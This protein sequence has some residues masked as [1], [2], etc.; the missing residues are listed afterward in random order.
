MRRRRGCGA[1]VG[2]G[3]QSAVV[4]GRESYDS[5]GPFRHHS[6]IDRTTGD[7]VLLQHQ[8]NGLRGVKRRIAL[9]AAPCAGGQRSFELIGKPE[10]VHH[11]AAGLVAKHTVHARSLH[12]DF[13][14]LLLRPPRNARSPGADSGR[15]GV[16][17]HGALPEGACRVAVARYHRGWF[18]PEMESGVCHFQCLLKGSRLIWR[19]R[20]DRKAESR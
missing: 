10:V 12:G 20:A 8:G 3:E 17:R 9:A 13:L 14:V 4:V 11:L 7:A 19:R 1:C 5:W 2:P 15:C 18:S 6:R 16:Q